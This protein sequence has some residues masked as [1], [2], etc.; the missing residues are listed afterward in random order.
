MSYDIL[1]DKIILIPTQ[2]ECPQ[3]SSSKRAK[4][5]QFHWFSLIFRVKWK[6][7][8]KEVNDKYWIMYDF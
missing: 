1:V 6:M 2:L 3:I 4:M 7:K 8:N 5:K